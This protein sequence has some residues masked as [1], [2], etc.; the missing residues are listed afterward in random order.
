M[1]AKN[2]HSP[3]KPED[4]LKFDNFDNFINIYDNIIL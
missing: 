1:F 2:I 3:L 4:E